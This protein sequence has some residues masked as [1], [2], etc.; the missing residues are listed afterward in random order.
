MPNVW[1]AIP[2]GGDASRL[3][4][5]D[6]SK[7]AGDGI[8]AEMDFGDFP[9]LWAGRIISSCTVVGTGLTV[10][11]P[12]TVNAAGYAV[13]TRISGGTAGADYSVVFTAALNDSPATVI[14]RTGTLKVV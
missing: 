6:L 14:A 7:A 2:P 10:V 12:G 5:N 8:N 11:S 9:E 1:V 4:R 3:V 13:S